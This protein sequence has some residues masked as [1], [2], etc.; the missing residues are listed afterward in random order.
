MLVF[1]LTARG[2]S[3]VG[4]RR[5]PVLCQGCSNQPF[6]LSLTSGQA[7]RQAASFVKKIYQRARSAVKSISPPGLSEV[8]QDQAKIFLL[9]HKNRPSSKRSVFG[10]NGY[11]I[12]CNTVNCQELFDFFHRIS[13]KYSPLY[14]NHLVIL[15]RIPLAFP[16]AICYYIA[17]RMKVRYDIGKIRGTGT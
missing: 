12:L 4:F 15:Y 11:N 7:Q 2:K 13:S 6:H 16:R 5:V 14:K 3:A 8:P 1:E 10:P 17:T 9:K